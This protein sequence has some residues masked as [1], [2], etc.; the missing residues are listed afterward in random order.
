[1]KKVIMIEEIDYK[2]VISALC[3]L[4]DAVKL[5]EVS[6][7]SGEI[8]RQLERIEKVFDMADPPDEEKHTDCL[9]CWRDCQFIGCDIPDRDGCAYYI[10]EDNAK[11]EMK[12]D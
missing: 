1:M 2:E 7:L 5:L 11:E 10:S 8:G 9:T 6:Y 3:N 12:N 4:K